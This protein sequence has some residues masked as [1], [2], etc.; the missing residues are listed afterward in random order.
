MGPIRLRRPAGKVSPPRRSHGFR[1]H[2]R[3]RLADRH[4]SDSTLAHCGFAGFREGE[5]ATN[6]AEPISI[7]S[8]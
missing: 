5:G 7:V 8:P 2:A 6:R 4:L 3:N 1:H